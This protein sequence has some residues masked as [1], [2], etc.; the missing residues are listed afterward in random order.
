MRKIAGLLALLTILGTANAADE[1]KI[2]DLSLD[3]KIEGEN[4]VFT[5][6]MSAEG[7]KKGTSLPLV[8][9]DVAYIDGKIPSS[10]EV[11]R[12]GN[13]YLLK[14]KGGMFSGGSVDVSFRFASRPVKKGDWRET[15]FSIPASSIRK[16]SVE[17]D[18]DDLEIRF[19]GALDIQRKK[20]KGKNTIVTAFLGLTS[21]FAGKCRGDSPAK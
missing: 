13:K 1:V 6:K 10:C 12:S 8:L 18:R 17:C 16:L 2:K 14:Y 9:G 19:P 3:G 4:I 15:S 5:L 7:L 11:A 20:A 21:K